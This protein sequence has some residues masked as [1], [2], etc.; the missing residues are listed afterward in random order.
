MIKD[1]GAGSAWVQSVALL[2]T[3]SVTLGRLLN[4]LV[5]QFLSSPLWIITNTYLVGLLQGLHEF[6]KVLGWVTGT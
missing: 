6:N 2:L 5:P 3:G 4:T 1:S